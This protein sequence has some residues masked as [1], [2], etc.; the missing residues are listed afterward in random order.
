MERG[1]LCF[2]PQRTDEQ[3]QV[4]MRRVCL[5]SGGKVIRYS[6]VDCSSSGIGGLETD[7]RMYRQS[8]S[9]MTSRD[10]V[11]YKPNLQAIVT[12]E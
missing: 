9:M 6:V 8:C 7:L 5:A 2:Y 3:C 11:F 1:S 4:D 10:R 12:A